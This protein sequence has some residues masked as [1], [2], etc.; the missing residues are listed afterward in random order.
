MMSKPGQKWD[1][2]IY[3]ST[4]IETDQSKK[5]NILLVSRTIDHGTADI[6]V[7]EEEQRQRKPKCHGSQHSGPW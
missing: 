7:H 4:P 2:N 5:K 6:L 1:F 3:V